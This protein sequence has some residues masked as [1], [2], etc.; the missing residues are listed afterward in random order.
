MYSWFYILT[1]Y[2]DILALRHPEIFVICYFFL[3]NVFDLLNFVSVYLH[4][5]S[6]G[7]DGISIPSGYKTQSKYLLGLL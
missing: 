7:K 3:N 1:R 6:N 2:S 4:V 5:E